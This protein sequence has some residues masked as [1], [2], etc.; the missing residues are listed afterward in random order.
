[1]PAGRSPGR[2]R[3]HGHHQGWWQLAPRA[4]PLE[5]YGGSQ[6][7]GPGG[8]HSP[9]L[10]LVTGM[11][12]TVRSLKQDPVST[13][14]STELSTKAWRSV[15]SEGGGKQPRPGG[16]V[17]RGTSQG[18]A[19]KGHRHGGA[20][21]CYRAA[22]CLDPWQEWLCSSEHKPQGRP[23]GAPRDRLLPQGL[24]RHRASPFFCSFWMASLHSDLS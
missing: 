23:Q 10:L 22:A 8:R 15:G 11:L 9:S 7:A 5:I 18:A 3:E 24:Q 12:W 19:Q 1:M 20:P 4:L 2:E 13:C 14:S 6:G 17:H 21:R 16:C